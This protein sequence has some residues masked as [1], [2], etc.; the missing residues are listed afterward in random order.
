MNGIR[1]CG[2]TDLYIN[3]KATFTHRIQPSRQITARPRPDGVIAAIKNRP[4]V[5]VSSP[6][7]QFKKPFRI[8]EQE[9]IRGF[10]FAQ[11]WHDRKLARFKSPTVHE[12][13]PT[14]PCTYACPINVGLARLPGK[15]LGEVQPSEVQSSVLSKVPGQVEGIKYVCS[16]RYCLC[17]C[18]F[19]TVT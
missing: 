4:H 17:M 6:T 10:Y 2:A 5:W 15:C 11:S 7:A 12:A 16:K 8:D 3:Y 18:I 13:L 1:R 14:A 19:I 9:D